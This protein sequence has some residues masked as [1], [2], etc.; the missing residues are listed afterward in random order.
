MVIEG[1]ERETFLCFPTNIFPFP[2]VDELGVAGS[3]FTLV[4]LRLFQ[5]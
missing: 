2:I 1:L 3:Y 4:K 5:A